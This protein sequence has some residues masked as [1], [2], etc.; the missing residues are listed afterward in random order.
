MIDEGR[1]NILGINVSVVNYATVV[2]K[3]LAACRTPQAFTVSALA[4][5]GVTEGARDANHGYRLNHIDIL[6][7][8]GQPVRW[9]LN[10]IYKVKLKE[11][12][13]GPELML[14]ICK[15]AANEQ[16]PIFLYGSSKK[17]LSQLRINLVNK[18]PNLKIAG[19]EPSKFRQLSE[20][21][22]VAVHSQIAASGAKIVFVGLGCPRQEVWAYENAPELQMP[23][24]AVGAAFDFNAGL[25]EQAPHWMQ[26]RGLEWLF[27]LAQEPRRLYRRY[28]YLN[29]YFLLNLGL[30]KM[31]LRRNASQQQTKPRHPLNY[32]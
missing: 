19:A 23:V 29:S 24:V 31:G 17:V 8:D 4:V 26:A 14:R 10:W 30:Q 3:V 1:R 12:V 28:L 9:A 21:E 6:A 22:C 20:N 32:G 25:L 15:A 7:P 16:I 27:R 11:R 5:H 18:H 2:S 13:Y